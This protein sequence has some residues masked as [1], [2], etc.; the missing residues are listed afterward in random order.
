M[1]TRRPIL[2]RDLRPQRRPAAARRAARDVVRQGDHEAVGR[3]VRRRRARS[4]PRR[5]RR[6]ASSTRR[7]VDEAQRLHGRTYRRALG[8]ITDLAA[9]RPRADRP[10][11][12][13]T[14]PGP[15]ARRRDRRRDRPARSPAVKQAANAPYDGRYVFAGTRHDTPPVRPTTADRRRVDTYGDDGNAIAARDRPGRRRRRSTLA[16]R[17]AS[18]AAARRPSGNGLLRTCATSPTHLRRHAADTEALRNGDLKALERTSTTLARR[19]PGSAR[20]RTALDAAD[21]RLAQHRGDRPPRC[22]PNTEDADM[23]EAI[24]DLST[25]QAVYQAA[26]RR[27]RAHHADVAA[28]LPRT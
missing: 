26:L 21:A 18:S 4:R 10:G 8:S 24:L 12:A 20:A 15:S 9:A 11:R 1:T 7:N 2:L 16:R 5:P 23:A 22:S 6:R 28:G 14:R 19:A 3:P 25:Q 13:T 27:R 17:R